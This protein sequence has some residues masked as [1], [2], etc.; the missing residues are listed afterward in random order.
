MKKS[1]SK[2][3]S[4]LEVWLNQVRVGTI[5]NLPYD[6]N[7]FVFDEE[8]IPDARRPVLSLGF[9]D[10]NGEL[11][12]EPQEVQTRVPPFFSNLLPEG[13]LRDYL[14]ERGGIKEVREFFLLWLLGADLPGAVWVQDAEGNP[15]PPRDEG[16][17]TAPGDVNAQSRPPLR[18]S[19]AGVQLKFSA[20]GTGKQLSI[21]AEGR[22]GY[23]IVKLPHPRFPLVPE[24]E[25]SMMTLAA[26]IGIEVAEVGLIPVDQIEGLP[27]ELANDESNALFV[28]RFDRTP[29][30]GKIHIEDFN[31]LYG[32][33]PGNAKYENHSYQ[34]MAADIW[35]IIGEHGLR[36]FVRRLVFNA[37][38]GNH[39]MHLKNW[40]LIYPDARTPRLS[41]GYDFVSTVRYIEDRKM[42]LSMARE[43]DTKYLD[44]DLLESFAAR[45]R[46]PFRLVLDV[47]LETAERTVKAWSEMNSDLPLDSGM[48]QKINEQLKYVPLTR[49]FLGE[50]G[51]RPARASARQRGRRAARRASSSKSRNN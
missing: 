6:R 16:V 48:R 11:I 1:R 25:Y 18:F 43:K 8:Y 35:K 45:A 32:Q 29:E 30:G 2:H 33:F 19:L 13:R 37:A 14:A 50:A 3:P 51:G 39:D 26:R 21:P 31:Q 46:A 22:G 34:G 36:E 15:L 38:I 4:V 24:N 7:L 27:K 5:T 41:P 17:E 47:A 44:A 40:S 42:A 12:A 28:R 10:A 49:Q 23:W 20:I 9:Y